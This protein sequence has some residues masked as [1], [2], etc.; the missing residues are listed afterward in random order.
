M[1]RR[2]FYERIPNLFGRANQKLWEH[3]EE[4]LFTIQRPFTHG[5]YWAVRRYCGGNPPQP[6]MNDPRAHH[7]LDRVLA[8]AKY[9]DAGPI[10]R[11]EDFTE[12]R[13]DL[14]SALLH[15]YS[16]A[17]PIF[18]DTSVRGLNQLEPDVRFQPAFDEATADQY[19]AYIDAIQRLKDEVPFYF[20]PERNYYLTRIVQEALWQ[21]GL[22][23]AVPSGSRKA[24][25]RRSVPSTA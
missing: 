12:A 9:P 19:Q 15:F 5:N 8:R 21:L 3:Y 18:D 7:Q 16:P 2:E 1:R 25:S 23:S 4:A 22:E 24:P 14:A 20:V 17:Y 10:E 6:A 11:L 13:V